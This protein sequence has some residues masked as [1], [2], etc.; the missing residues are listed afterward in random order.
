MANGMGMQAGG[1]F[2][3]AAS[4][5]NLSQM[6][7]NQ[8]YGNPGDVLG[9]SA[10]PGNR[11]PASTAPGSTIAPAAGNAVKAGVWTCSCGTLNQG[12]FCSECGNP[13]P[14][15]GPWTCSCGTVNKGKFCS[16]CG[17]PRL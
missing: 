11:V 12:K 17:K 14:T 7:M 13:R 15:D 1:G 3:G 4:A 16:E 5:T 2:M 10:A 9:N 8:I 6:Q